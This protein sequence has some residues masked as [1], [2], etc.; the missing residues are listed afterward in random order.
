M[1]IRLIKAKINP[2][3]VPGY[4]GYNLKTYPKGNTFII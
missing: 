1:I 4:D 2:L 3:I